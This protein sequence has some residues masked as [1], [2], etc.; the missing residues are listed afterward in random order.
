MSGRGNEILFHQIHLLK[1]IKCLLPVYMGH[2]YCIL[3]TWQTS[4]HCLTIEVCNVLQES[5]NLSVRGDKLRHS[6][7]RL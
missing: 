5:P 4:I 7:P 6:C 1:P 2:L 3:L